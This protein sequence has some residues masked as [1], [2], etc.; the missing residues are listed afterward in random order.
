MHFGKSRS[1]EMISF[2]WRSLYSTHSKIDKINSF[3]TIHSAVPAV[4]EQY[5]VSVSKMNNADSS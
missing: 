1:E 4:H 5:R 2:F 3:P